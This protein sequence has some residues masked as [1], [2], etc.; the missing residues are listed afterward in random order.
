MTTTTSD[1]SGHVIRRTY[2]GGTEDI[3][4]DEFVTSA[5]QDTRCA[6]DV[7]IRMIEGEDPY[8]WNPDE[9]EFYEEFTIIDREG[10][11]YTLARIGCDYTGGLL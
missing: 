4:F 10:L 1:T 11:L 8:H 3:T 5:I 2:H 9:A 7:A 6:V